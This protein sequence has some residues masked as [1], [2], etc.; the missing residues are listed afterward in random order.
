MAEA[1]YPVFDVPSVSNKSKTSEQIMKPCPMFDFETGDFVRDGANRV[2]MADGREAYVIWVN[3]I[4]RTQKNAFLS[5][6]DIG[7]ELE[8]ALSES[9]R[10]AVQTVL[11]RTIS[12]ALFKHP[13]TERVYDFCFQWQTDELEASFKVKPKAWAAFDVSLNVVK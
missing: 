8:E 3:K 4:V 9:S 12:E 5:Y 6:I 11:E 13:C 2:L 7:T 1:L 10:A